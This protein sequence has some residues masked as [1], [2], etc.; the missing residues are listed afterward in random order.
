[1]SAESIFKESLK[2]LTSATL[3]V[4]LILLN[5]QFKGHRDILFKVAQKNKY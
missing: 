5:L 3:Q 1:M 4:C 2:T